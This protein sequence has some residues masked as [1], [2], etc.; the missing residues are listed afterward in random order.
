MLSDKCYN[1]LF[2]K[3]DNSIVLIMSSSNNNDFIDWLK[4]L[5]YLIFQIK[6]FILTII[7]DI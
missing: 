4:T 3:N 1:F 7:F 6:Y 5:T 2:H